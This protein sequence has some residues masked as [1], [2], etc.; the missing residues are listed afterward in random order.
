V[1]ISAA[2]AETVEAWR[3]KDSDDIVLALACGCW[4]A[5]RAPLLSSQGPVQLTRTSQA[6]LAPQEGARPSE[7][8]G[9]A[10]AWLPW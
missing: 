9:E 4:L 10:E 6:L 2:G 7:P 8:S 1:K 5:S 3:N